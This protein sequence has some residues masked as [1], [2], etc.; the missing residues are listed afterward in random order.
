MY[1]LYQAN[2]TR[3]SINVYKISTIML[4]ATKI[5]AENSRQDCTSWKSLALIAVIVSCPSPGQP[6]RDSMTRDPASMEPSWLPI[7]V[8]TG[9]NAFLNAYFTLISL[10]LTPLARVAVI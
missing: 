8:T 6:N 2:F 7:T 9:N 5:N 10:L 3:L 1:P 4:Q